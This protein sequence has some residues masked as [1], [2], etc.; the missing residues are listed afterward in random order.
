DT[1]RAGRQSENQPYEI[2]PE[3]SLGLLALGAVG[4]TE[5]RYARERARK[6]AEAAAASE[7]DSE[8]D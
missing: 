5:W 1:R 2:P 3:G 4:I 8:T 6:A 7:P